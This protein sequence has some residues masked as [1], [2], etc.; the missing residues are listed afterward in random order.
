MK[1]TLLAAGLT[2]LNIRFGLVPP[3]HLFGVMGIVIALDF[4]TGVI[5][6]VFLR[7]VRTSAGY[8]KTVIKFMQYG[9]SIAIAMVLRYLAG[10]HPEL[11]ASI[12]YL[13]WLGNGL[14]IF[15]IMIEC[16]SILENIYAIDKTSK[17][18]RYLIKPLL[19]LLTFQLKNNPLTKNQPN[20][21][22][23]Q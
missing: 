14:M 5:K 11:K 15:I 2:F 22:N 8:R 23:P 20:E 19:N 7:Q 1:N 16:T 9:G 13:D 12:K 6:S 17:M 4:L 21:A 18:S 3:T 10:L